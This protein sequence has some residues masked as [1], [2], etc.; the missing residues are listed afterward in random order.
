MKMKKRKK[1]ARR[2]GRPSAAC[3][4]QSKHRAVSC[5]VKPRISGCPCVV[6]FFFL[7]HLRVF[8]VF[9]YV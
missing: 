8:D 6:F 1:G 3:Q 4:K 7:N 5:V 2:D 9:N